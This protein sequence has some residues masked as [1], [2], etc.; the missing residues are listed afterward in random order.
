MYVYVYI[1]KH[2]SMRSRHAV[3]TEALPLIVTIT[4]YIIITGV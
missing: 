2:I 4:P 3:I 1:Y